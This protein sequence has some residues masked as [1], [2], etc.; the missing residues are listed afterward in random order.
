MRR[1]DQKRLF[2][3]ALGFLLAILA[4]AGKACADEFHLKDGS[5]IVGTIVGFENGAF[6]VQTSYGFATV[7]KDSIAEILPDEKKA[8]DSGQQTGALKP[9]GFAPAAPASNSK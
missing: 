1:R 7:R 3:P 5:K 4:V 2:L 8:A 9:S 6:K